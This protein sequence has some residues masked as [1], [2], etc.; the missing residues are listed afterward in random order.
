[1]DAL[2]LVPPDPQAHEWLG[3][4]SM[5]AALAVPRM[6]RVKDAQEDLRRTLDAFMR[7]EVCEEELRRMLREEMR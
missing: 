7:S 3:R 2:R 6:D 5:S 4:L 1:M